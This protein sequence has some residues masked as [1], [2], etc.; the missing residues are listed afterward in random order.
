LTLI[1]ALLY[2]C[3]VN[4]LRCFIIF[5]YDVW[6]CFS[7]NQYHPWGWLMS[8]VYIWCFH[9]T[10]WCFCYLQISGTFFNLKETLSFFIFY[11]SAFHQKES[12]PSWPHGSRIYNYLCNQCLFR[13]GVLDTTL[14]DKVCQSLAAG[15]WFSPGTLV[16][17]T[18]K[19]DRYN[20]I[21]ILL[22]VALHTIT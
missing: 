1:L 7:M 17:S 9:L 22:T 10:T 2:F 14:C 11:I 3:V 12:G 13:R 4:M 18:N 20:I 15:L 21:E 19:N 16:S 5:Y 8:P 6:H